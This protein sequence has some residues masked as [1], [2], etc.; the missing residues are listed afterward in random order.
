M[1]HPNTT[2]TQFH[3]EYLAGI[4]GNF[5]GEQKSGSPDHPEKKG[6]KEQ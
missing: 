2:W 4:F 1:V 6:E 3:A 5:Y